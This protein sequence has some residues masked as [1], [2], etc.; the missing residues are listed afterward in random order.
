MPAPRAN[1]LLISVGRMVC[2]RP[3]SPHPTLQQCT[4]W[5]TADDSLVLGE[6]LVTWRGYVD[7]QTVA[8]W[9][10]GS[11]GFDLVSKNYWADRPQREHTYYWR[12]WDYLAQVE[13][14]HFCGGFC[15]PGPSLFVDYDLSGRQGGKCAPLVGLKFGVVQYQAQLVLWTSV[16]SLVLVIAVLFPLAMPHL[17]ELGYTGLDDR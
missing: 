5:R 8:E 15:E 13:A 11:L 1:L 9:F 16:I 2:N 14:N 10:L 7:E 12:E 4:Q 3:R 17:K 6:D